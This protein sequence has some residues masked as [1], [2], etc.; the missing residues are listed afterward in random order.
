MG[1]QLPFPQL[2]SFRISE[3]ST[4]SDISSYLHETDSPGIPVSITS[5]L[6]HRPSSFLTVFRASRLVRNR[7]GLMSSPEVSHKWIWDNIRIYQKIPYIYIYI[8]KKTS[9]LIIPAW[10][11]IMSKDFS[12]YLLQTIICD[13]HIK[14]NEMVMHKNLSFSKLIGWWTLL[15]T[16]TYSISVPWDHSRSWTRCWNTSIYKYSLSSHTLEKLPSLRFWAQKIT[17]LDCWYL[18]DAYLQ[19]CYS[20]NPTLIA[21]YLQIKLH[22]VAWQVAWTKIRS[23]STWLSGGTGKTCSTCWLQSYR[24]KKS[25]MMGMKLQT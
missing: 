20:F 4:V 11:Q 25:H 3:A 16:A 19:A 24:T 8:Y 14:L 7:W 21:L 18:M 9:Y 17:N 2:V 15:Q 5:S 22:H 23:T 1:Y 6:D 12:P 13:G 10:S